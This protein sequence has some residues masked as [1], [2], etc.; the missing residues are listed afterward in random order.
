M[1]LKGRLRTDTITFFRDSNCLLSDV[2]RFQR[3]LRYVSG[4]RSTS[5]SNIVVP[6]VTTAILFIIVKTSKRTQEE[7]VLGNQIDW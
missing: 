5:A 1:V 3:D 7:W 4:L 2:L 6:V